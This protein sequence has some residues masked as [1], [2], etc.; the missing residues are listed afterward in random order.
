MID[1]H[2]ITLEFADGSD[3]SHVLFYV[4]V[5]NA[6]EI[7]NRFKYDGLKLRREIFNDMGHPQE[8][9]VTIVPKRRRS[10]GTV[11]GSNG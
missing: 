5:A 10:E 11:H 3:T 4:P 8:I 2:K 6:S 7:G 1:E 9:E